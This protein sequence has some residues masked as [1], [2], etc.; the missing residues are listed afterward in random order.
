[1]DNCKAAGKKLF[2]ILSVLYEMP[3]FAG[4]LVICKGFFI[5]FMKDKWIGFSIFILTCHVTFVYVDL[6][7]C[8]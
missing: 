8:G 1:M 4:G 7:I 5:H 3:E 2:R 6:D